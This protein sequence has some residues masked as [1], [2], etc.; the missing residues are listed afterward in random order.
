MEDTFLAIDKRYF[1]LG[2]KSIDILILAQVDE[3]NR[4]GYECYVT[5]Q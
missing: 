1:K 4:N 5:N 2:L 3:F